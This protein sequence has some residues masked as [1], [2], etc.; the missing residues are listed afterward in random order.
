MKHNKQISHSCYLFF[1][2]T[3]WVIHIYRSSYTYIHVCTCICRY[4]IT[5]FQNESFEE[6][7]AK[8]QLESCIFMALANS[9]LFSS[10]SEH[11][12][13]SIGRQILRNV[14]PVQTP[15]FFPKNSFSLYVCWHHFL[16]IDLWNQ[17]S[18]LTK[19]WT[20]TVKHKKEIFWSLLPI[21]PLT[22]LRLIFIYIYISHMYVC[23]Y[24]HTY[25]YM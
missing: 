18:V 17:L 12:L 13:L 24:I 23:T 5:K 14:F 20:D 16:Y 7:H 11:G 22:I 10:K 15:T 25:S 8:E 19:S 2:L 4:S 1:H 6:K 9:V 21:T 3:S